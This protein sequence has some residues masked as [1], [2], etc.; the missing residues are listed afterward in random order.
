MQPRCQYTIIYPMH[1]QYKVGRPES[2]FMIVVMESLMDYD[3]LLLGVEG[4]DGECYMNYSA[5]YTVHGTWY[6]V[7]PHDTP[8]YTM[9]PHGTH[10]P[11]FIL[12]TPYSRLQTMDS[13]P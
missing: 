13:T 5:C 11:Y 12:R 8:G 7:I 3:A 10:T 2:T 9:K 6:H 1:L 4:G